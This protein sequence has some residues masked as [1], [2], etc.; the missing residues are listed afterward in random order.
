MPGPREEPYSPTDP[1]CCGQLG[2][3]APQVQ[4]E[5]VGTSPTWQVRTSLTWHYVRSCLTL[6]LTCSPTLTHIPC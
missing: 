1:S 6:H 3:R 5:K 2:P 4:K